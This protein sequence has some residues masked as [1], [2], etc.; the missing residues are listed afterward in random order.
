[1]LVA[2]ELPQVEEGVEA[3]VGSIRPGDAT[4]FYY[5]GHGIQVNEQNY[6]IPVDF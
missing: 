2:V 6:L 3:F 5:S 1:M 4:V